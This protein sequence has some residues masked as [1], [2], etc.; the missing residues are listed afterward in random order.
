[1]RV[2]LQVGQEKDQGQQHHQGA[3]DV[4]GQ[5]G[6]RDDGQDGG[7]ATDDAGRIAPAWTAR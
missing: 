1:M 7:D 2:R 5:V 4:H 3:R 6:E